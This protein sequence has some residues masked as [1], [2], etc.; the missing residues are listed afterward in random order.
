VVALSGC[1]GSLFK[2]KC[3]LGTF[4]TL[5]TLLIIAE[6]VVAG[7]A[8]SATGSDD[9]INKYASAAWDGLNDQQRVSYQNQYS[10]CG[11]NSF[12]DRYVT[13]NNWGPCVPS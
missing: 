11:F 4:A 6:A 10:C 1:L 12:L 8:M 9:Q 7:L 2:S 5:L 13:M 3:L